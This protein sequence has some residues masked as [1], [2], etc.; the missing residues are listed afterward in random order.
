MDEWLDRAEYM[1]ECPGRYCRC[2]S[3]YH[4]G[5]VIYTIILGSTYP[6]TDGLSPPVSPNIRDAYNSIEPNYNETRPPKFPYIR[7][8]LER[9]YP[10]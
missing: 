6:R 4:A 1:A 3:G 2:R 9:S 7:P 10:L 5:V 8:F